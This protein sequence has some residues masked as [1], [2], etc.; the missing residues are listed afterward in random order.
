ERIAE[1]EHGVPPLGRRLEEREEIGFVRRDARRGG[2][3]LGEQAAMKVDGGDRGATAG[4]RHRVGAIAGAEVQV[5][6][7]P[8]ERVTVE[9]GRWPLERIVVARHRPRVVVAEE[10]VVMLLRGG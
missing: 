1:T 8:G 6:R 10:L 3:K 2:A 9:P 7:G 4:Q 5:A